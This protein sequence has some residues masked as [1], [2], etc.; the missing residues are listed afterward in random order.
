MQ[1]GKQI[2]ITER[3]EAEG[4]GATPGDTA[5]QSLMPELGT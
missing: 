1:C 2:V 5:L 3:K 4:E